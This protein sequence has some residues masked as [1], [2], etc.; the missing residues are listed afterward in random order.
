M[1]TIIKMGKISLA[2]ASEKLRAT[3]LLHRQINEINKSSNADV[4][5]ENTSY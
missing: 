3:E 4:M 5:K 1:D 2:N